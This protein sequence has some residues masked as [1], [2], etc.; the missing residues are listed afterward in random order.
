[1]DGGLCSSSP[2]RALVS[3]NNIINR[4]DAPSTVHDGK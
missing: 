3:I 1:V 2:I 4:S